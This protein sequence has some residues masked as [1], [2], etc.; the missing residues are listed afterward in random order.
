MNDLG[1]VYNEKDLFT[2]FQN[3]RLKTAKRINDEN[4]KKNEKSENPQQ[5]IKNWFSNVSK[6]LSSSIHKYEQRRLDINKEI[7]KFDSKNPFALMP[8]DSAVSCSYSL[9]SEDK[10]GL[11]KMLFAVSILLDSEFKYDYEQEG[12]YEVSEILY[13]NR[14][15]LWQLKNTLFEH[16]KEISKSKSELSS[17]QKAALIGAAAVALVGIATIPMLLVGGVKASAVATTT[18]LAAHGFADM[19]IGAG[20]IAAEAFFISAAMLGATYGGMKIYNNE[21]VKEEFRK[22]TPERN[23]LY[24][25][26]Q[27]TYIEKIKKEMSK[28]EFKSQLDEILKSME[29]LKADLDYYL[30]VENENTFANKEKIRAFHEFDNRL[31]KILSI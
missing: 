28:E 18:A 12:I 31:V 2:F 11:S 7:E 6:G 5:P 26:I 16:Y 15:T 23:S 14:W 25:A 27:C 3:L 20:I 13:G 1:I 17:T 19:Q 21:K 24:L 9:F 30:Y 22:L 10:Y 29:L 4:I 8:L